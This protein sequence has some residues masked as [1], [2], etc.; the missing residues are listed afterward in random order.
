MAEVP[1]VVHL[2]QSNCNGIGL[3]VWL[4]Y[5]QP[6]TAVQPNSYI[7]NSIN[8]AN[9]AYSPGVNSNTTIGGLNQPW[10]WGPEARHLEALQADLGGDVYCFK[11]AVVG[12][13]GPSYGSLPSWSKEAA[14]AYE[15]ME[16]DKAR[17]EAALATAEDTP[18]YQ[19]VWFTHGEADISSVNSVQYKENLKTF[20]TDLRNT[21]GNVNLPIFISRCHTSYPTKWMRGISVIRQAQRDMVTEL[22]DLNIHLMDT[23]A[24]DV[25]IALD[26]IHYSSEGLY[27]LGQLCFDTSLLDGGSVTSRR[28]VTDHAGSFHCLAI[29]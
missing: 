16:I 7:W 23:D 14:Q 28:D 5:Y 11:Q 26:P 20:A 13:L 15:V 29:N 3:L 10:L 25:D 1:V 18:N 24:L 2:G 4:Q 17:F 22:A 12:P 21:Y 6:T 8:K 19:G 27:D 9:E